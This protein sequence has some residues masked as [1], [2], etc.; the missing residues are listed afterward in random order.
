MQSLPIN[1]P[2]PIPPLVLPSPIPIDPAL[3]EPMDTTRLD[4][5][6][7]DTTTQVDSITTLADT[8][9]TPPD[10]TTTPADTTTTTD[11]TL[12]ITLT[13]AEES[14]IPAAQ[15][16]RDQMATRYNQRFV[17]ETFEPN[18]VV[19]VRIPREDRG[20]LDYSRLYAKVLEQPHPGRYRLQTE[21]GVLDLLYTIGDLNRVPAVIGMSLIY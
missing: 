7:G 11:T 18:T 15:K 2:S 8:T 4:S 9:T 10:T 6:P 1:P 3:V 5:T 19:S 17:I 16:A 12:S 21:H 13:E 14:I 20:T